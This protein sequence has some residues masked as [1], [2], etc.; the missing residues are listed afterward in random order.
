MG[1]TREYQALLHAC[2]QEG[3]MLCRLVQESTRR[4]LDTWK[5]ELFT[6]VDIRKELRRTQG[7][8]HTHTW[9]LARMGASLPIAQAYREVISDT[10]DH[11]KEHAPTAPGSTGWRRIF[12]SKSGPTHPEKAGCLACNQRVQAEERY[13]HSLRQALLDS[14]FCQALSASSGLCLSHFQLANNL[15]TADVP[16]NWQQ[17]LREAQI[18][19]LERLDAQLGE[20]IRKHDYRF[21]HEERGPEMHSWRRAA[22]L[23]SGEENT[24]L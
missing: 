15:R 1:K 3:C 2:R 18:A 21:Q 22:G 10:I 6:D 19:C 16:G 11:L 7:F 14:D 8:C 24:D 5:Y 23:V 12:E 9:Q 17:R 4:Y 13:I 20:L